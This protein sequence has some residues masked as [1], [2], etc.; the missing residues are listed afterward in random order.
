MKLMLPF[1]RHLLIICKLYGLAIKYNLS[2]LQSTLK[3]T[4]H[5]LP[6][7]IQYRKHS[8]KLLSNRE[9]SVL[10]NAES[11]IMGDKRSMIEAVAH[12]LAHQWFG[13]LVTPKWWDDT[14]LNEGFATYM[15]V[16]GAAAAQVSGVSLTVLGRCL[17]NAI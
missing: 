1:L 10:F 6:Y 4:F 8:S 15:S 5:I 9:N 16:L 17:E 3:Q 13:N 2:L 14:W 12:E 7:T 11:P